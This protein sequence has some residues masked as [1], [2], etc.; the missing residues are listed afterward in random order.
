MWV[1]IDDTA[2]EIVGDP[3]QPSVR[4]IDDLSGILDRID[5]IFVDRAEGGGFLDAFEFERD[6]AA[7]P[8]PA[9]AVTAFA[10]CSSSVNSLLRSRCSPE[11]DWP[12]TASGT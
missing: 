12:F 7:V 6:D 5:R 1:L 2:G 9:R 10:D 3:D 11:P 4:R 8:A